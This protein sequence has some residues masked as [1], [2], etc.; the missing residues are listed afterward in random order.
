MANAGR[1]TATRDPE[2]LAAEY[3]SFYVGR[4]ITFAVVTAALGIGAYL[5]M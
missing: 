3:P 1:R 4:L 2:E 5:L